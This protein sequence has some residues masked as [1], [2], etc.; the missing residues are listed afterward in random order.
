MHAPLSLFILSVRSSCTKAFVVK[1]GCTRRFQSS[2]W[3]ENFLPLTD[4]SPFTGFGTE[5]FS[6]THGAIKDLAKFLVVSVLFI[7]TE[8]FVKLSS[9]SQTVDTLRNQVSQLLEAL[10]ISI[11]FSAILACR[12]AIAL[13]FVSSC[14]WVSWSELGVLLAP[15]EL[16]APNAGLVVHWGFRNHRISVA[17]GFTQLRRYFQFPNW[18]WSGR[19]S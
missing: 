6:R 9:G 5:F 19:I 18:Q 12:F 13:C 16:L 10:A 1:V 8:T 2:V 15:S 7:Y 14:A 4:F 3:W 11:S 17:F